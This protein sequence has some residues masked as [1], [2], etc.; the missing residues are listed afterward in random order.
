LSP[1]ARAEL[2]E[3]ILK[4]SFNSVSLSCLSTQI[5]VIQV[6]LLHAIS[7]VL[8]CPCLEVQVIFREYDKE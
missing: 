8:F 5:P 3:D 2:Q 4:I 7:P 1:T 6:H